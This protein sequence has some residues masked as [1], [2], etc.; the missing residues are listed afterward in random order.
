MDAGIL[1]LSI[2]SEAGPQLLAPC[3]ASSYTPGMVWTEPPTPSRAVPHCH[4][5]RDP[6]HRDLSLRGRV[7]FRCHCLHTGDLLNIHRAL[8]TAPALQETVLVQTVTKWRPGETQ[9][10]PSAC[11]STPWAMCWQGTAVTPGHQHGTV[12]VAADSPPAQS[13]TRSRT[14]CSPSAGTG[15]S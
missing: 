3:S 4:H 6:P 13:H 5:P 2:S 7:V 12:P 8:L 1:L 14:A 11:P 10:S 15:A 9:T